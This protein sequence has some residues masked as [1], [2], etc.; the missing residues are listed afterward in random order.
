MK[1]FLGVD[2]NA[3]R[4]WGL[5]V[6]CDDLMTGGRRGGRRPSS[7]D[8]MGA[9]KLEQERG[10]VEGARKRQKKVGARIKGGETE[11]WG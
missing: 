7:R 9:S 4:R 3:R 10:L 5:L 11:M 8:G 6:F 2:C 1:D